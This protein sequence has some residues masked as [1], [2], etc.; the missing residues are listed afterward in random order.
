MIYDLIPVS[1][2]VRS[3]LAFLGGCGSGAPPRRGG[4]SSPYTYGRNRR[5]PAVSRA[6]LWCAVSLAWLVLAL[7]ATAQTVLVSNMDKDVTDAA[8]VNDRYLHA[9]AFS[10]PSGGGDYTFTSIQTENGTGGRHTTAG[11]RGLQ[12]QQAERHRLVRRCLGP[13][14]EFA[15][16]ADQPVHTRGRNGAAAM[17]GT[18]RRRF[19]PRGQILVLAAA[20]PSSLSVRARGI[21]RPGRLLAAAALLAALRRPRPPRRGPGPDRRAGQQYGATQLGDVGS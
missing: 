14:G 20:Y 15:V 6:C 19:P 17:T 16:P 5:R 7:P 8:V 10:V 3:P 9:Q 21:L 11:R 13:P 4:G 12:Y 18:G 1:D 2:G